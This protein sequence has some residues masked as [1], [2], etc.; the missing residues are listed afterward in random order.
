MS[1][2]PTQPWITDDILEAKRVRRGWE[3]RARVSGTTIARQEHKN[4]C[5][6]VKDLVPKAKAQYYVK[7][8]DDC[9]GDQK[10]LFQIVSK[11]LGRDKKAVMPDFDNA[12]TIAENFNHFFVTKIVNLRTSLAALGNSI[13]CMQCPPLDILLTPSSSKLTCFAPTTSVEITEI[14]K[15]S[16]NATCLLDPIPTGLLRDLLPVLSPIIADIVNGSL[17]AGVFP[18]ELKSAI[19]KPLLKKSTLDPEVL[20]N[21]RPVSNLSF[22]SKVIEKV[23]ASR[24]LDHMVGNDLLEPFQS[25]Y[26]SGH[27]TETALLRV[28]NDIVNA[29]DQGKGVCLILLD[30]S[31]AFDTVDH[32]ILLDFLKNHIGLDGSV[33]AL[34]RS[35]LSGRSQCVSV[36]GVL[37]EL[38]E[39]V[40]GVPQGSVLGPI[41]FCIYTIPLGAI[42]RHY[43]VSYHIHADDTQLYLSFD[44]NSPSEALDSITKC[45]SDIRS[46]M[47]GNKL[48][49]NDDKTE[50]LVITSSRS[51]LSEEPQITIGQTNIVP[52]KSCRSLGV[53]FDQHMLMDAHI[54]YVCRSTHFHLRNIGAIRDLLPCS[55]VEQ[56]IHSLVTSRL[57][58]CNSLLYG[59]PAY[60]LARIQR[61]QNIAARIVSRCSRTDHI[62]PVLKAL[63][64]LPVKF[65]VL[66]KLLLL[67]YRCVYGL[68]PSYLSSLV[69]PR[70]Y[71]YLPRIQNQRLLQVPVVRLK[72]YGHR[73]FTFSAPTEWNKLPVEI[74]IAPTLLSFKSKLKTYLYQLYFN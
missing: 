56:L 43:N 73:S 45:I 19:V 18:S 61:M 47:I 72:S 8:I 59:V 67:T 53:M 60:K 14:I 26:R 44:L 71:R 28:H 70:T 39:L 40:F 46:W 3:R 66:F 2:R 4:C 13:D 31:A 51:K 23:V 33:L 74:R 62:T 24:L 32:D 5:E 25:A 9:D 7:A 22:I 15:K 16:S 1:Q 6:R 49:I 50:F 41:E 27:S 35:Y 38:S 54:S 69:V 52:A 20:K 37:S 10:K 58:Y 55:A 57:D 29:V 34:F 65:R 11:L 21:F 48:K 68:A 30:L 42:M 64:W 17:T 63:H 12:K 36:A